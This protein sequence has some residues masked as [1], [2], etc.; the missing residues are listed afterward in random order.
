M[1]KTAIVL[2][3]GFEQDIPKELIKCLERNGVEWAHYDTRFAFWPEN[4][5]ATFKFFSELPTNQTLAC[6][7]VF[8]G[9][10]Q[11][12]LFI[13]LLHKL[14]D[15]CFTFQIMNASLCDNLLEF[16]EHHESS[17]T[18][19]E[20]FDDDNLERVEKFKQEM[21]KKFIEVLSFHNLVWLREYN[22]STDLKTLEDI[23]NNCWE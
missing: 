18:P 12:E 16:Y 9:F 4:R 21:N 13:N 8:D 20:F 17:L 22:Y 14:K 19:E 2:E 23:K 1:K 10:Q 5:E 15:K 7:H 3:N 11:L 6:H